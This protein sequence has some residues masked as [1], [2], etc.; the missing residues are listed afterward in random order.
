VRTK[1]IRHDEIKEG[2]VVWNQ[3]HRFIASDVR[4]I[5]QDGKE[6]IVRYVGKCADTNDSVKGTAYDGGNYGANASVGATVEE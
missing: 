4:I 2:M 6:S 1:T 5:P 3:G